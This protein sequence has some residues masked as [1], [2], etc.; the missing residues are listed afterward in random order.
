METKKVI[1]NEMLK[2]ERITREKKR[3][4]GIFAKL[5]DDRKNAA[6]SLIENAAFQAVTLADLQAAINANGVTS[7]YQNG[8][9]QWGT[10]KSPEIELYTSLAKIHAAAIKQLTDMLP[11]PEPVEEEDELTRFINS[12]N[13]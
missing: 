13:G 10:K 1:C 9:N 4:D 3:L 5:D 6:K 7:E 11:K 2:E 12:R 8:A